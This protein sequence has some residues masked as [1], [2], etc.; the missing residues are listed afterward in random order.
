MTLRARLQFYCI[1]VVLRFWLLWWTTSDYYGQSARVRW[2]IYDRYAGY[3]AT[4]PPPPRAEYEVFCDS[5]TSSGFAIIY[6]FLF[7]RPYR[8]G[9]MPP[10]WRSRQRRKHHTL[11]GGKC[12]VYNSESVS[13]DIGRCTTISGFTT[14]IAVKKRTNKI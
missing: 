11:Y 1:R 6:C 5:V 8:S 3:I 12:Y 14:T 10:W 4:Q 7:L 13:T 2:L 9:Y